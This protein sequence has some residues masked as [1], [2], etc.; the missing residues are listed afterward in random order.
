[1][2][3]LLSDGLLFDGEEQDGKQETKSDGKRGSRCGGRRVEFEREML[4]SHC[5][6]EDKWDKEEID[7]PERSNGTA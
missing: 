3:V 4:W 2:F 5:F 7:C 1:M 6:S